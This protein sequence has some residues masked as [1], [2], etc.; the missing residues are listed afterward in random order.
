MAFDGFVLA[1]VKEQL[2]STIIGGTVSKIA[3]PEKD[4]LLI[5]IRNN[6]NNYRLL[7]SAGASLPLVY[8]SEENKTSPLSAPAF[9]MLL[10]K[11]LSSSKII[12]VS[13][14]GF[15]RIILF[16]FEHLNE[17]GDL[18]RKTLAFELMGKYSN[19]IFVD[20]NGIIIDSIKRVPASVSSLREVLPGRIYRF[21]DELNKLQPDTV[22]TTQLESLFKSKSTEVYRAL[23]TK[24]AG[25]SPLIAQEI[26]YRSAIPF[27]LN[28]ELLTGSDIESIH[29]HLTD[30]VSR[31][32]ENKFNPVII[33]HNDIPIEY[34]SFRIEQY[35]S[36]E[37][38]ESSYV[39][40]SKLLEDYYSKKEL[41]TRIAQ[42]TSDIRKTVIKL[43][44]RATKKYDLQRKQIKDCENKDKYKVYG[45]L[46]NTYGY[47]LKGGDLSFSC[48]NYYDNNKNI[49][50]PLD[51]NKTGIENAKKYYDKYSK[52]RRTEVALKSE[53]TKTEKSIDH[54]SGILQSI[55]T[56]VSDYDIHQ[57]QAE[58][59][60][61]GYINDKQN[62]KA[63]KIKSEPIHI[64]S[65]DGYDIYI[66]KNNYQNEEV[67]FKI[68]SSN[69]LWFHAKKVPGSHV[70]VKC[71]KLL[72]DI[73]DRLYKEAASLAAY[74]SQ[75]RNNSKVEVDYTL[76]KNLKKTPGGPP[77]YVIYNTYYS[78]TVKPNMKL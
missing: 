8:L 6:S 17:L 27:D 43:L 21:P 11:Y 66:G 63:Q 1:A 75:N 53:I 18:S 67:T 12:N 49:D 48:D 25:I 69:D 7:I 70:V 31:C 5:T 64:I 40:I 71:N 74:Y 39:S 51:P 68:A 59:N 38:T 15:D 37:Y 34:A 26:C 73:P 60:E 46:L 56:S 41:Q 23:Y 14:N 78:I 52:L 33:Y 10:R 57:I 61:Y 4:E 76:R 2:K 29:C 50:I 55:D 45:D 16:E 19:I 35:S 72:E 30:F 20:E 13:Q 3:M 77:G 9:C 62:I 22:D 44:E 47:S 32:I 65:S 28:T 58:L 54:L 36:P 24:V 42:K